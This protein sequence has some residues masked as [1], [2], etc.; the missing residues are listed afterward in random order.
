LESLGKERLERGRNE[1]GKRLAILR[2]ARRGDGPRNG[3]PHEARGRGEGR[4]RSNSPREG[5]ASARCRG[6]RGR[7]GLPAKEG[8]ALVECFAPGGGECPIDGRCGLKVRPRRA[9][10]AFLAELDRSTLAD[11]ALSRHFPEPEAA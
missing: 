10:A 5:I 3:E 2:N 9:E 7:V 1:A 4:G 6:V 8:Q 11:I